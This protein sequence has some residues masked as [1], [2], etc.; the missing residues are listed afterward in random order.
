MLV[1]LLAL[2]TLAHAAPSE[3]ADESLVP[4]V[5]ISDRI[6]YF[7]VDIGDKQS[8]GCYAQVV[9]TFQEDKSSAVYDISFER[10]SSDTVAFITKHYGLDPVVAKTT[11]SNQVARGI[12]PAHGYGA[13]GEIVVLQGFVTVNITIDGVKQPTFTLKPAPSFAGFCDFE[14][15]GKQRP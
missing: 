10:G 7:D 3:A 8:A 15:V 5:P 14:L 13:L 9:G 12:S 11:V 2:V 4:G 1:A 6:G